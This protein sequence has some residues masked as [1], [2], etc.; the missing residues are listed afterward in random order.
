MRNSFVLNHK[1]FGRF[2][3]SPL[4]LMVCQ[5][6]VLMGF[7]FFSVKKVI[8][9]NISRGLSALLKYLWNGY[10]LFKSSS[11]QCQVLI[12]QKKKLISVLNTQLH[13]TCKLTKYWACG[14]LLFF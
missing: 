13:S 5:E 6:V 2:E 8:K 1:L 11:A 14:L 7:F 9:Y 12:L 3:N 4:N 10:K